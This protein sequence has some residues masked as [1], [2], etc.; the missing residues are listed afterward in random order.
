MP[1]NL[2]VETLRGAHDVPEI[3][4]LTSKPSA[5]RWE[6]RVLAAP[7]VRSVSR[8]RVSGLYFRYHFFLLRRDDV[9]HVRKNDVLPAFLVLK[10]PHRLEEIAV[11][12]VADSTADLD[13]YH[14][15]AG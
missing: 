10:L 5:V 6:F 9:G 14:V 15:G 7:E 8:V 3:G 2:N 13:D 1:L 4:G 12:K 11:L